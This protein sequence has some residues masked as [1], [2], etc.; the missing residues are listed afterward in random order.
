MVED[1]SYASALAGELGS[2]ANDEE[3]Y[4]GSSGRYDN[5]S[6]DSTSE[7]AAVTYDLLVGAHHRKSVLALSVSVASVAVR[8][9]RGAVNDSSMR[10]G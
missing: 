8:G 1:R 7:D 5:S 2:Y 10:S 9:V 4:A 6:V 3:Y